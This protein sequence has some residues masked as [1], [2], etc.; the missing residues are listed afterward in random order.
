M[1]KTTIYRIREAIAELNAAGVKTTIGSVAQHMGI[2]KQRVHRVLKQHGE[3][4]HLASF[5]KR[6]EIER[7]AD[8]LKN[9][10]TKGLYSADIKKLPIY[11]LAELNAGE[12]TNM[13]S[14]YQIPHV[15]SRLDRIRLIRN[16][17]KYTAKEL[18]NMVGG[19]VTW[20]GFREILYVNRIPFKNERRNRASVAA[21]LKKLGKICTSNYTGLELHRLVRDQWSMASFKQ[22]LNRYNIPH[23]K[24]KTGPRPRQ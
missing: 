8:E 16:T 2:T 21:T 24:E 20:T 23:K 10:N 18:F 7:I 15:N 5:Q 4:P 17:E 13:L 11:G 9:Y 19:N 6:D 1:R 3:L 22:I 12:M 14:D